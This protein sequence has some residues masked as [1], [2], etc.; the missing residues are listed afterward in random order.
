MNKVI[1]IGRLTRDPEIRYTQTGKAVCD[2]SL[3]VDRPFT[4]NS[5]EREAD[6]INIVV[7]NKIAE[8]AAKYLAKGRQCAVEGRLQISS[9]EGNDS[10]RK[11][12]TDVV[13][14]SVE[15][16]GS[17]QKSRSDYDEPSDYDSSNK[18]GSDVFAG[19]EVFFADEDLPF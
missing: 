2:F 7:W 13:A 16:L 11:Y 1:L 17:K 10:V 14:S 6:F 12:R 8:N 9:Y 19:E 15:F 4:S 18:N 5:G 3:A